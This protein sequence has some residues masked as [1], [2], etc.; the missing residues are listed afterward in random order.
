MRHHDKNRKL[1]R[2]SRQREA[3]L[4][5]LAHS[6][7]LR[8]S[9]E[10]TEA[11]AKEVRPFVERLVTHAKRDTLAA[12]R[13]VLSRMGGDERVTRKLFASIAPKFKSRAGGY[14]R[15]IK[16]GKRTH[17]GRALAHIAFVE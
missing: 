6:L 2:T 11:K 16:L 17:D 3:L 13:H 14:T 10:T 8:G 1:S 15:I 12:R 9:M 5:S 4:R 7:I